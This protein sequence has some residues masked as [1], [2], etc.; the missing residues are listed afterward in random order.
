MSEHQ[1]AHGEEHAEEHFHE[2]NYFAIYV[3]LVILFLISVM[4][5]EIGTL[6]GM[7]WI[8]LVTA[9]GIAIVKARLVINNF[10]HLK[11]EKTLMKWMLVTS[12]VLMG[13]L[14]AGVSSDVLNHRGRNWENLAAQAAIERGVGGGHG[15]EGMLAGEEEGAEEAEV[16]FSAESTFGLVCA[17]C[18]GAN[19]Q[20]DGAAGVALDPRP[21]NFTD[22]AFWEGRDRERIV[23]VIANGAA[24][25]GGSPLM[26]AWSPSFSPEEIE[27]LADH[28]MEFRPE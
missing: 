27:Q 25:V 8:T 14:L 9:F 16:G 22:P 21:A 20:G 15:E 19:G 24:S 11:W 10:M 4:G 5:P 23:N 18:H 7:R 26:V 28:V 13:L 2:V 3:A 17:T 6:T 1:A 12:L